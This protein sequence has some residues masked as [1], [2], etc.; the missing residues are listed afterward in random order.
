MTDAAEMERL[1]RV[2][3]GALP[4]LGCNEL[5]G[6]LADQLLASLAAVH[7]HG[8]LV[9]HDDVGVEVGNHDAIGRGA[10]EG[11]VALLAVPQ[12]LVCALPLGD[13]LGGTVEPN[14][15][16][17]W[18]G[19]LPKTVIEQPA[20]G[21][22]LGDDANFARHRLPLR[23]SLVPLPHA[24]EVVRMDECSQAPAGLHFF[25]RE[26]GDARE[27]ACHPLEQEPTVGLAAVSIGPV[28][29]EL[30]DGSPARFGFL[31]RLGGVQELSGTFLDALLEL[32]MRLE[33]RQL[34]PLAL[35]DDPAEQN[36]ER[37]EDQRLG[38]AQSG[39][40]DTGWRKDIATVNATEDSSVWTVRL[41]DPR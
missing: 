12:R 24:G 23:E 21:A 36:D 35:S 34:R 31:Q 17:P 10:D 28:G 29:G 1:L 25:E 16:G 8:L 41:V 14:D 13:V 39:K 27:G 2:V 37:Q 22:A 6:A 30:G 11:A 5:E 15:A 7:G 40:E 19:P 38:H 3:H 33:H 26:S 20:H 18:I 4:I 9:D 32:I